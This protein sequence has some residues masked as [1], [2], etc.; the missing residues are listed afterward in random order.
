M[1]IVIAVSK[2][3]LKSV[4][5]PAKSKQLLIPAEQLA[6]ETSIMSYYIQ[7]KSNQNDYW[8]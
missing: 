3:K 8:I 4:L 7:A 2:I 6:G 5:D 1:K